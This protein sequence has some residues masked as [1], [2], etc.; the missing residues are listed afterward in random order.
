MNINNYDYGR[1]TKAWHVNWH[2][3][4]SVC[5]VSV[6]LEASLRK[7]QSRNLGSRLEQSRQTLINI[8]QFYSY[9]ELFMNYF[10]N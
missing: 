6:Y 5:V 9:V 8:M 10:Y 2:N 4:N 7:G 3:C 1:L